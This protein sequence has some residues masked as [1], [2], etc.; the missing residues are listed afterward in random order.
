MAMLLHTIAQAP[1]PAP[2]AVNCPACQEGN[3]FD[4]VPMREVGTNSTPTG[5]YIVYRCPDCGLI[6]EKRVNPWLKR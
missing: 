1:A 4:L 5:R 3:A 6:I 2:V